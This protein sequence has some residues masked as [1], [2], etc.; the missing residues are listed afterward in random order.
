MKSI[1]KSEIYGIALMIMTLFAIGCLYQ[2]GVLVDQYNA[3]VEYMDE[4]CECPLVCGVP[5][6]R[7]PGV[8]QQCQAFVDM[9]HQMDDYGEAQEIDIN[10][11]T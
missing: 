9:F 7:V 1:Q 5:S 2:I 11:T 6:R 3:L 4:S 10:R 8:T